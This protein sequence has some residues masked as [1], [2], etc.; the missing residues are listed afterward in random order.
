MDLPAD[1]S[2]G[3][4]KGHSTGGRPEPDARSRRAIDTSSSRCPSRTRGGCFLVRSCSTAGGDLPIRTE[5][6]LRR[7]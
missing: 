2:A 4:Q 1:G 7:G 3:G 5:L 6:L